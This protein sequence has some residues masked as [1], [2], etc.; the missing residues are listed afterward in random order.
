[1][2]NN[3]TALSEVHNQMPGHSGPISTM[4]TKDSMNKDDIFQLF[5]RHVSSGKVQFFREAGLDFIFGRREGV[6]IY[7]IDGSREL[8]DCHCNGGV[9]N[10]GHRHPELVEALRQALERYDIGNHHFV[11]EQRAR[12]AAQLAGLAPGDLQYAIFASGGGEAID[13]AI[14]IARGATGRRQI[15]SAKGGYHG[16]TGYALAAG[17]AKFRDPFL[18]ASP[19]FTQ[20]PF[21]DPQAIA[22]ALSAETAAV[23]METIPATIGMLQPDEGY[24]RAVRELCTRNGT[25]LIIDEVQSGLGRTGTLWAIEQFDCEPDIMVTAK[26]LSGGLYPIAATL[27]SAEL[28]KLFHRDPFVHISTFGGAELGCVVASK[29][30]EISA[31]ADFLAQVQQL[32]VFFSSGLEKIRLAASPHLQEIRQRGLM[33]GLKFAHP[34][35]GPAMARACFEAGLL[36]VFS[37]NDTSVLQFLPPL[38]ISEEEAAEILQ[39]LGNAIALAQD[40]LS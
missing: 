2:P 39:R 33:T 11:S 25:L 3:A 36:C 7:D 22:D 17:D 4:Q 10:L 23:I 12:L 30:L 28:E 8:Y 9:F 15:I 29:V 38:I 16:H 20:V 21:N 32:S 13:T 18:A 31:S 34:D 37:G 35:L 27:I 24:F 26:G 6:R 19:D 5:G 1:M 14:K 40:M